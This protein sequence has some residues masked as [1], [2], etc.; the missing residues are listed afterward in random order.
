MSTARMNPYRFEILAMWSRAVPQ[1]AP[2]VECSVWATDDERLLGVVIMDLTDRDYNFVILARDERGRFRAVDVGETYFTRRM[3]DVALAKRL[4]EI[5]NLEDAAF[6]QGDV[7]GRSLDLFTPLVPADRQHP[8]FLTLA[9]GPAFSAARE[10]IAEMAN[11][12][13]DPDGNF[14]KDFQTTGF[15]S[16]LW[17]LY[18]FAVLVEEGF[19][20]DRRH[21]Q[22]DFIASKGAQTIAIEATTVNPSVGDDG[23]PVDPPRPERPEDLAELL[24]DYMPIKFGSPLFQK[25]KKKDW[26]RNHVK[27]LPYAIAIAD[28][29]GPQTMTWSSSALSSYLFGLQLEF[30][31]TP[32]G[33]LSWS[34]LPIEKHTHRTKSIPSGFFDQPDSEN[35]AAVLFTNAGTLPKFNRMGAL[36]DFGH[37]DV[38]L[39]RRG[40][41][42]NPDPQSAVPFQVSIDIDDPSY[43]EGWADELQVF[44]NPHARYPLD[45]RLFPAATHHFLEDGEIKSYR[46]A[47]T[48]LG[49]VTLILMPSADKDSH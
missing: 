24:R 31:P 36:A 45:R 44:H 28:F 11:V 46:H 48:W 40:T 16:R 19:K 27:G 3:A 21:P 15:N 2:T 22:P 30:R 39:I 6:E 35:V 17:E 25:L 4:P 37:P 29:H 12:F 18:L 33:G 5:S 26:E 32:D 20:L 1:F 43:H 7:A 13:D 42:L 10:V 23:K 9:N 38:R 41:V 14:V 34:Y 8:D 49:S 47:P